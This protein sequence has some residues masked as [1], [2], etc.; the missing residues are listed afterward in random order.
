M[1]TKVLSIIYE[2]TPM[3]TPY[4][5]E[6]YMNHHA[7]FVYYR[8]GEGKDEI[9][10]VGRH[11]QYGWPDMHVTLRRAF[12]GEPVGTPYDYDAAGS[13]KDGEI[14]AWH[15]LA[16][17]VGTPEELRPRI[18]ELLRLPENVTEVVIPEPTINYYVVE[19]NY[20]L[21]IEEAIAAGDFKTFS[22][23]SVL[24]G[25]SLGP[26]LQYVNLPRTDKG[27]CVV[28][29]AMVQF[30]RS[31]QDETGVEL[32]LNVR[33]LRSAGMRELLAFGAEHP[34]LLHERFPLL[35]AQTLFKAFDYDKCLPNAA[36]RSGDRC[37]KLWPNTAL[38]E[39]VRYLALE[40]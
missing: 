24:D 14:V 22:L 32:E 16:H 34:E 40:L 37:L 29:M 33:N 27:K 31:F 12:Y 38:H 7:R 3:I 8:G 23:R 13:I 2:R 35:A 36:N 30:H 10:L 26:E 28:K 21:S 11:K 25:T 9:L 5:L 1:T 17:Q 19:I 18:C 39:S 20:S 6:D 4:Q 15:D